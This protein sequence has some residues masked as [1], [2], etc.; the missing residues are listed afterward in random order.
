MDADPPSDMCEKAKKQ[1][2]ALILNVCSGHITD[3][4]E[5]DLYALGCTSEMVRDLAVELADMIAMGNCAQAASCAA[6]VNEGTGLTGETWTPTQAAT[7][8]PEP[9]SP[10]TGD[11]GI[12][13]LNTRPKNRSSD[14]DR[15]GW[16]STRPRR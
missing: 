10:H 16:R 6:A 1:T 9:V 4:C 13:E 7:T 5:V 12:R 15:G 8:L 14:G 11:T 3:G 2:T